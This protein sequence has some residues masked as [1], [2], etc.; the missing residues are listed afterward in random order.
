MGR[1]RQG[2]LVRASHFLSRGAQRSGAD[3][4]LALDLSG[5]ISPEPNFEQSQGQPRGTKEYI[6]GEGQRELIPLAKISPIQLKYNTNSQEE[7]LPQGGIGNTSDVGDQD[8]CALGGRCTAPDCARH[9]RLFKLDLG[10]ASL[11]DIHVFEALKPLLE[12]VFLY[13]KF[14]AA[15]SLKQPAFHPLNSDEFPPEACGYGVRLVKLH[16][17]MEKVEVRHTLKAGVELQILVGNIIRVVVPPITNE[18]LQLQRKLLSAEKDLSSVLNDQFLTQYPN[19]NILEMLQ[20]RQGNLEAVLDRIARSTFFPFH[21]LL[22]KGGR[23][24]FIASQADIFRASVDAFSALVRH[25]KTVSRLRGKVEVH[26][27]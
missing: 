24:D 5:Q 2:G 1:A 8:Q 14:S 16:G 25:K 17:E 3:N 15:P 4:S 18:L 6:S 13:K 23:A 27:L 19:L 20:A 12:G 22:E 10:N 7:T 21:I 26:C 9:K 11:Q